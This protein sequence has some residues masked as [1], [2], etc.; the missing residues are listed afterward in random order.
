MTHY[1]DRIIARFKAQEKKGI[2]KYGQILENNNAPMLER[3]EH[4]AQELTDGLMYVEWIKERATFTKDTPIIEIYEAITYI[5][6]S[7]QVEIDGTSLVR[8]NPDR[9]VKE[10]LHFEWG[11]ANM[12][13]R[14]VK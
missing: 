5:L 2:K 4:L 14:G 6:D 8:R 7:A 9:T 10:R 11:R 12:K 1:L 3:L 13:A